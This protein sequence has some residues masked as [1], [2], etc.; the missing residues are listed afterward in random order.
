LLGV[1]DALPAGLSFVNV[2]GLDWD[3]NNS[4][5]CIYQG[6][7]PI[8]DG[9]LPDITITVEVDSAEPIINCGRIFFS[10]A[11]GPVTPGPDSNPANNDS[12]V[13]INP[14]TPECG[15]REEEFTAGTMDDFQGPEPASPSPD[16]RDFLGQSGITSLGQFDEQLRNTLFGHTFSNLLDP[17]LPD[18]MIC[19]A[20]LE[21]RMRPTSGDTDNDTIDLRFVQNRANFG[22][23]G[24]DNE[25]VWRRF[26]GPGQA[27]DG[28][29]NSWDPGDPAQTLVLDLT[30]LPQ[31]DGTT[32]SVIDQLNQNG[33]LDILIQDDTAV[34]YVKLTVKYQDC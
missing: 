3:C 4:I 26:L 14:V 15:V 23:E 31:P 7:Y 13:Q 32:I 8:P 19:A 11:A 9:L 17:D 22:S 27:T 33:F 2:Q 5:Q 21:I 30:A 20:T 24:F 16:L 12:C 28:I 10:G 29:F 1:Q 6:T 34:D 25:V 18:Q